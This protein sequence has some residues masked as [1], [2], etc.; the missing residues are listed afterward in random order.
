MRQEPGFHG[1]D[2]NRKPNDAAARIGCAAAHTLTRTDAHTREA[3]GDGKVSSP[4]YKLQVGSAES[5]LTDQDSR[6]A[7]PSSVCS[8]VCVITSETQR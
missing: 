5:G 2:V 1:D 3:L 8:S 6:L 7:K 4:G